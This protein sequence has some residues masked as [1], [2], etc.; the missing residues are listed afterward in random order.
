MSLTG[1]R[2]VVTRAPHQ[3]GELA[4][5]LRERGAEPL[6]YPCID[7]QPPEDTAEL[8]NAL[9]EAANGG[10]D[11]LVLTSANT[12]EA[13]RRR[14]EALGLSLAHTRTAAV[15]PA[16][17]QAAQAM[18][19]VEVEVVPEEHV[20]EALAQALN[21]IPGERALLPQ[22]NIARDTLR[23]L[24]AQAGTDVTAITS[25]HTVMGRGGVDLPAL[26]A[27][28]EVDAIT[29]T[30]SSTVTHCVARVRDEDGNKSQLTN[31]VCA[32]IGP[33]TA[34]TAEEA[35]LTRVLIPQVYTLPGMIESLQAF[36]SAQG[37][38]I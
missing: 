26:L 1:R 19:G 29:F 2:I 16:T 12:V 11:W 7:I 32:C 17:A 3:A 21:I 23:D 31:V 33:K 18:L 36:W 25:Y 35:G 9:R 27:A 24:L 14:C 10:F 37:D 8:D 22:A 5:L 30:S 38:E 20:A 34:Q 6:L 4:D 13:L 15:G 28:G